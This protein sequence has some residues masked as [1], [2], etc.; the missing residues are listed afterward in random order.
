M[1]PSQKRVKLMEEALRDVTPESQT[2]STGQAFTPSQGSGRLNAIE[3]ALTLSQPRHNSEM[4]S[5]SRNPT[6]LLSSPS[7][8]RNPKT[9]CGEPSHILLPMAL[10]A[11]T[12]KDSDDEEEALWA[13][14][15]TPPTTSS[16][17]IESPILDRHLPRVGNST[18]AVQEN[19]TVTKGEPSHWRSDDP[20]NPFD[21]SFPQ[22][23][24]TNS[25]SMSNPYVAAST[26]LSPRESPGLSADWIAS[27]ISG[28]ND[29]PEYLRK[30]ER[31]ALAAERSNIAKAR[32]IANLEERV[33]RLEEENEALKKSQNA[34]KSSGGIH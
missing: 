30:L 21:D 17:L 25:T 8:P 6:A 1:T 4:S 2:Q 33:E 26:N 31:K 15:A 7:H 24:A 16:P 18:S 5:P 9:S 19:A 13:Q 12:H 3:E 28:L 23:Q 14:L 29:I 34:Y 11:D 32:R 10:P 20:E 27:T 22:S